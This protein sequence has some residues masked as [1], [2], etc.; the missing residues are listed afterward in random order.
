M[1]EYKI[2]NP[3]WWIRDNW[4]VVIRLFLQTAIRSSRDPLLRDLFHAITRD[5]IA[6]KT[7]WR[8]SWHRAP[9]NR[10]VLSSNALHRNASAQAVAT[11]VRRASNSPPTP[12]CVRLLRS[13]LVPPN[14][15]SPIFIHPYPDSIETPIPPERIIKAA[16]SLTPG[17]KKFSPP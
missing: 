9:P 15:L 5:L 3:T 1:H 2:K 7:H 4:N 8:I 10:T 6:S 13:P 16:R 11:S 14:T 17:G 12:V